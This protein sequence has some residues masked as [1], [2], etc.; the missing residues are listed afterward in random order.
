[1]TDLRS[2]MLLV[3]SPALIDPN[4]YRSVVV[5]M[6]YGPDGAVGLVLDRPLDLPA[7]DHLPE[8]S[9]H[10]APPRRVFE[11]GPVQRET[12][13]G[14]AYRPSSEP[15]DAW[16]PVLGGVGLV[17]VSVEPSSI[18]DITEARIFSGYAGWG[19]GQLEME[20]ALGSWIPVEGVR[21]DV[22][23]PVPTSLWRRVLRRQG[24][25]VA[26]YAYYPI[27]LRTN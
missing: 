21:D 3:A 2:G 16:R 20:L 6:D 13:I 12:A 11:G 9:D 8:W 27:D 15:D 18:G 24:G 7:A 1:M 5:L 14:L 4:F 25:E 19:A 23:D 26:R 22:F 10:L 17:D